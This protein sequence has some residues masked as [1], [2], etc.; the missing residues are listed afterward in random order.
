M[1]RRVNESARMGLTIASI[2][3]L[4]SSWMVSPVWSFAPM[5]ISRQ[6]GSTLR[7]ASSDDVLPSLD[8]AET[9]VL[10]CKFQNDFASE[11]GKIYDTV[12]EVMDVTNMKE[13]SI[14]FVELAR[15]AGCTIVHC[16][17]SLEPVRFVSS[18]LSR[19][20]V[21]SSFSFLTILQLCHHYY[22]NRDEVE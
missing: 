6:H 20:V 18:I 8:P 22:N 5:T 7:M 14:H 19:D 3:L 17:I 12:K 16:P 10:I 15:K 9:A 21:P 2:G 13:N 4:L 11:G 1:P